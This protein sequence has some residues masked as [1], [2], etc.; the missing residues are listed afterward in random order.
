MSVQTNVFHFQ[1]NIA[2]PEII[3]VPDTYLSIQEAI[4]HA[5]PGETIH[6]K[7]GVYLE[8]IDIGKNDLKIVGENKYTTIIDGQGTGTVDM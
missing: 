8:H 7:A 3:V 5:K 6:V 4:N 1:L 2:N